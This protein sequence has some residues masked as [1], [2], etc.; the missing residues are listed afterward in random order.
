M[1]GGWLAL[2]VLYLLVA[3]GILLLGPL[4]GLLLVARPVSRQGWA[5][6][7]LALLWCGL[8]M[9]Q[10]GDLAEQALR[11]YSVML[12]GP[13][14][15]LMRERPDGRLGTAALAIGFAAALTFTWMV[16]LGITWGDIE[17]SA[18]RLLSRQFLA[19]ARTVEAMG[20][21]AARAVSQAMYDAAGQARQV[22]GI[23]PGAV[24]LASLAGLALAWRGHH[25]L[26]VKPLG[27]A[28]SPFSAFTFSDQ[29]VW[30]V[31]GALV[32]L[33][34]PAGVGG[35]RL[36]AAAMNLLLVMLCL[37]AVRGAAIFRASTGRPS[38]VGVALYSVLTILMFAF[39]ATGL[40]LLG[41]ADTW[42]D[43]RRRLAAPT[44]GGSQ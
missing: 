41:L 14:I 19:Q 3:P 40:M 44:T 30:L 13:G 15:A 34:L 21:E 38:A 5:V 7:F 8:W 12:I 1:S 37:Y 2:V 4:A 31:V 43:F 23:L 39:V 11:S 10:V 18:A 28:P 29:A 26:A 35:D 22:A 6:I 36:D 33:L 24:F 20:G 17:A 16:L 42:L 32:V 25:G 27:R 9:L